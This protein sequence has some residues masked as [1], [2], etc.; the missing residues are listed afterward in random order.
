ML[1]KCNL[2]NVKYQ[3]TNTTTAIKVAQARGVVV[4]TCHEKGLLIYEYTPL[5]IKQALTGFGRAEKHQIQYMTKMMLGLK[6]VPKPDDTADALAV[7]LTHAQ[8]NN[9]LNSNLMR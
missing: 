5:Q 2:L 3:N 1:I 4:A 7:A 6:A 8:T 9:R